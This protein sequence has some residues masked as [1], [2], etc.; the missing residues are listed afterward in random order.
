MIRYQ[1]DIAGNPEAREFFEEYKKVLKER[2]NQLDIW[3]TV[4]D[5]EVI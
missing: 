3:I 4:S 1:L 2:F 5:T